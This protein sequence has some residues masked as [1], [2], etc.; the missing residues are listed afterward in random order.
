MVSLCDS[1]DVEIQSLIITGIACKYSVGLV[2]ERLRVRIPE[3]VAGEFS[4]AEL[5]VCVD[6]YSVSVPP[7]CHRSDT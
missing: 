7:P 5:T 2:I 1:Q 6:S 3:G 4:S